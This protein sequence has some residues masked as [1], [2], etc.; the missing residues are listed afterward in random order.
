MGV[1]ENKAL[2]RRFYEEVW[3]RGNV[4]FAAEVFADD[5]IRHD[6]RPTQALPGGAGMAKLAADFRSAF[7][8]ARW[9]VDLVFGEGDLVAARWTATGTFLGQWG[10]VSPTGQPR[11]S[12]A[13]TSTGSAPTERSPSF[14]TIGTTWD[15]WSRSVRRCTPV[16]HRTKAKSASGVIRERLRSPT[17]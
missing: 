9:H 1:S 5:Y 13:S 8:D 10:A 3:D 15:S 16:L 17:V 4:D 12:L 6:L 2:V 7:P 11:R 14:G